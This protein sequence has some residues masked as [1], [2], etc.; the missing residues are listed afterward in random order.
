LITPSDRRFTA[1]GLPRDVDFRLVHALRR[2]LI[3]L[4]ISGDDYSYRG[5]LSRLETTDAEAAAHSRDHGPG[6]WGAEGGGLPPN[7]VKSYDEGRPP[8]T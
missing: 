6:D 4:G 7:Y 3:R 1:F 2:L 5:D 8:R